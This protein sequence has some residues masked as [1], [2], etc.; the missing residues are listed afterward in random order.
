[1]PKN[2]SSRLRR[3]AR[4]ARAREEVARDRLLGELAPDSLRSSGAE[5]PESLA[6]GVSAGSGT[7]R[8]DAPAFVHVARDADPAAGPD[9]GIPYPV[10]P[11]Q[12]GATADLQQ[13]PVWAPVAGLG[14]SHELPFVAD[15]PVRNG[16][17]ASRAQLEF[18][19]HVL[20]NVPW[21]FAPAGAD[22]YVARAFFH[23]F[24]PHLGD[25]GQI[26]DQLNTYLP[27][28]T[29]WAVAAAERILQLEVNL[30]VLT[31]QV[32]TLE[33]LVADMVMPPWAQTQAAASSAGPL[34]PEQIHAAVRRARGIASASR[35][36]TPV[37]VPPQAQSPAHSV[38]SSMYGD[39]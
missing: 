11:Y 8:A 30:Q 14:G 28:N 38:A 6:P 17:P 20:T 18:E 10:G 13:V 9:C 15:T 33:A 36:S 3:E 16:F 12:V 26:R 29:V 1:M 19:H 5:R 4:E 34:S 27:E 39:F 37:Y 32:R 7:L 23:L 24:A 35:G 21:P 25:Y 31:D 2:V 22:R